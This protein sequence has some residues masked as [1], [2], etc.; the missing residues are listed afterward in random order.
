MN[1]VVTSHRLKWSLGAELSAEDLKF[2]DIE[3][4]LKSGHIAELSPKRSN[5]KDKLET[6]ET[7]NED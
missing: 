7:E 5:K 6:N 1:Y 3:F 4:L 2:A